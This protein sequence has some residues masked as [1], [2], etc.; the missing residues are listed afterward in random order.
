V[1]QGVR[2]CMPRY[3]PRAYLGFRRHHHARDSVRD[4]HR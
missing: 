2:M 3:A 4:Q 1:P